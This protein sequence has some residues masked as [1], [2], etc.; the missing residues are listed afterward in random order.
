MLN[1]SENNGMEHIGFVTPT[2]ATWKTKKDKAQTVCIF[3]I[4]FMRAKISYM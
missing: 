2:P 4:Q 3:G 1:N